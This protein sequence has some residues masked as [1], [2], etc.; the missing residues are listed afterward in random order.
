ML[1]WIWKNKPTASIDTSES[2]YSTVSDVPDNREL[3]IRHLPSLQANKLLVKHNLY[4]MALVEKLEADIEKKEQEHQKYCN[5]L[6][7]QLANKKLDLKSLEKNA[8][9]ANYDDEHFFKELK[10]FV[11][12][13]LSLSDNQLRKKYVKMKAFLKVKNLW[14]KYMEYNRVVSNN[15]LK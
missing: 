3:S 6:L 9:A 7:H 11:D 10:E 4:L 5:K 12:A 8:K 1:K 2:G 13:D 15:S 14:Y